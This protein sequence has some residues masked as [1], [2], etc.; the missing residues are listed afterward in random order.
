MRIFSSIRSDEIGESI[1]E[2]GKDEDEKNIVWDDIT[3]RERLTNI[4]SK[5]LHVS[6]VVRRNFFFFFESH[7]WVEIPLNSEIHLELPAN[8]QSHYYNVLFALF[9]KLWS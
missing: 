8:Y 9:Q 1:L 7:S 3:E 5:R 6:P 2:H 4:L